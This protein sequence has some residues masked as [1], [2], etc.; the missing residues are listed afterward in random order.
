M[1]HNY[2]PHDIY[3]RSKLSNVLFG[4]TSPC[5]NAEE[6]SKMQDSV[7]LIGSGRVSRGMLVGRAT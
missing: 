4:N 6:Q 5:V 3:M 1:T 2:I 7:K